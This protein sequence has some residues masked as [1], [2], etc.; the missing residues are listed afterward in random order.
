MI[1]QLVG[2][3]REAI[4]NRR[5]YRK[6]WIY[7]VEEEVIAKGKSE[8]GS[9][10]EFHMGIRLAKEGISVPEMY[11]LIPPDSEDTYAHF[12]GIGGWYVVMQ[13]VQGLSISELEERD[14]IAEGC[15]QYREELERVIELGICPEDIK[16]SNAVFNAETN[17][18]HLIDFEFW[19]ERLEIG[20]AYVRRMVRR[21]EKQQ[22]ERIADANNNRKF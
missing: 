19:R 14:L 15:R 20:R 17:R 10:V 12:S 13:R 11:A 4:I 3:L 1:E 21:I 8:E 9:K 5:T 7:L 16:A 6:D 22:L 2:Q 18:L